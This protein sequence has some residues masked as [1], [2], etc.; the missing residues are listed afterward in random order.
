MQFGGVVL[1]TFL[2][3]IEFKLS[4]IP[5]W[6]DINAKWAACSDFCLDAER[7][8]MS[9]AKLNFTDGN[10]RLVVSKENFQLGFFRPFRA[11]VENVEVSALLGAKG[12]DRYIDLLRRG[13]IGRGESQKRSCE[14][15]KASEF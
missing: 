1:R 10:F 7:G 3:C 14:Y 8:A 4:L 2:R 15:G 6:V 12:L 5:F 11:V 13:G 9:L